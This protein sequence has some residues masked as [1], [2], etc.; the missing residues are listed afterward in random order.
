M[1]RILFALVALV[2]TATTLSAQVVPGMKYKDVKGMYNPKMYVKSMTDP[3]SP[4]LAGVCSFLVPG[5]GQVVSGETGRGIAFFAGDVGFGV[6][7]T[8]CA[9]KFMSYAQ[10]DANGNYVKDSSGQIVMTDEKAAKSWAIGLASVCVA[11]LVY[12]IWGICDAVKVA[13]VKN[14]YYQDLQGGRSMEMSLYPSVDLAMSAKGYQ[15]V[16]GMTFAMRF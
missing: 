8:A 1:K 2:L 6:A 5:L 15:P 3:Y 12:D 10:K 9:V 7:A 4:G 16:A 11:S 14:M 13:K